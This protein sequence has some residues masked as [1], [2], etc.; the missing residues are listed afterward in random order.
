[1]P[2]SLRPSLTIIA[3]LF[4]L[5]ALITTATGQAP[6]AQAERL[7]TAAEVAQLLATEPISL[8]TWP[9]WCGTLVGVVGRPQPQS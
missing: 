5:S 3:A 7:P 9:A 8:A 2:V 1:M 4:L 6:K